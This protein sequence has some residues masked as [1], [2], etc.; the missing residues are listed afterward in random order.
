MRPGVSVQKTFVVDATD[1][2]VW[3]AHCFFVPAFFFAMEKSWHE[4]RNEK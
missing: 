1:H 2:P 4:H 3:R